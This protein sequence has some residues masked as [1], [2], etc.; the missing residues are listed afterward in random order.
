[1]AISTLNKLLCLLLLVLLAACGGTTARV[2][3]PLATDKP[4][5]LYFYTDN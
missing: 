4:T 1:M 2:D 5:F 3:L